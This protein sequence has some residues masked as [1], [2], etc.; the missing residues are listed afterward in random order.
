MAKNNNKKFNN[1]KD[2][3]LSLAKQLEKR[4]LPTPKTWEEWGGHRGLIEYHMSHKDAE[5]ILLLQKRETKKVDP[6]KWL[7][8]YVNETF[9]LIGYCIKVITL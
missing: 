7:C 3:K 9:G 2:K 5:D 1:K 4:S 6:Q 8:D